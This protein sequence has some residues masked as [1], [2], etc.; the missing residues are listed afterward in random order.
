[1]SSQ[2]SLLD[3]NK[4]FPDML[5]FMENS[6]LEFLQVLFNSFQQG[7]F[8]FEWDEQATEL[9]IEGQNTDNL[10]TVDTGRPKI[11]VA[12]GPVGWANASI[13]K[14]VGSSNLSNL[15]R[16]YADINRGTVSI[17]CFS[18]EDMEAD[19]IAE[20]CYKAITMFRPVLQKAGFLSINSV[21]IGQRGLIVKDARPEWTVVPVLVK[22]DITSNW[23]VVQT[24]SVKLR[25]IFKQFI[26]RTPS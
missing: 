6:M 8:H 15:N 22:M 16:Q 5:R 21:Q 19:R 4:V 25:D 11:V 12:R 24:D 9:F 2:K 7:C 26:M 13:G 17:N 1:M 3:P 10:R 18:R 20:I 23:S 14:F